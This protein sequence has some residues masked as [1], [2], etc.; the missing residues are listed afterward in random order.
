MGE[1]AGKIVG[2]RRYFHICAID[3]EDFDKNLIEALI[4]AEKLASVERG[5]AFNVFSVDKKTQSFSLLNYPDFF[6]E[7][8]PVL[9]ES[10]TVNLAEETASYRTYQ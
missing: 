8:F 7:G 2:N 3:S 6:S 10:W 1:L 5:R 4:Q 9:R